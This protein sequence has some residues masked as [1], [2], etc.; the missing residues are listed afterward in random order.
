MLKVKE[1]LG[2]IVIILDPAGRHPSWDAAK[3]G[4]ENQR[5]GHRQGPWKVGGEEV[6]VWATAWPSQDICFPHPR[7][8][9]V[10]CCLCA[11]R[12]SLLQ[13]K[14]SIEDIWGL[15]C[16]ANWASVQGVKNVR[17][18]GLLTATH[19]LQKCFLGKGMVGTSL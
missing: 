5:D 19:L 4:E 9:L 12:P 10:G 2:S 8:F 17:G 14:P 18:G 11:I 13:E 6:G 15:P 1:S 16:H 7:L 3:R